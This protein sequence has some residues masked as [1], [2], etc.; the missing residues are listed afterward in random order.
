MRA[1]R[2]AVARMCPTRRTLLAVAHAA[3]LLLLPAASAA[4]AQPAPR[5]RA[6]AVSTAFV[7]ADVAWMLPLLD[8]TAHDRR[9]DEARAAA[10]VR[11]LEAYLDSAAV[12]ERSA[13]LRGGAVA[14]LDELRR[15]SPDAAVPPA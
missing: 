9:R 3:A 12:T 13:R 2:S 6:E 10:A 11:G 4:P 1:R 15:Y 5:A 8:A 14:A 7:D